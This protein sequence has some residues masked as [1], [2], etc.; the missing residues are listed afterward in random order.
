MSKRLGDIFETQALSYL[1]HQGLVLVDRNVRYRYGEI[2][3]VMRDA[4]EVIVFVEV[5]ARSNAIFGS[6]VDSITRIKRTRL[7]YAAQHYL[8]RYADS[9]PVCRFD[10]VVFEGQ[11]LRWLVDILNVY[12]DLAH[13]SFF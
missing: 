10:A 8:A 1:Q 3:L 11:K 12:G 13:S 2:D 6:A 5:R 7:R 9:P 4:Q